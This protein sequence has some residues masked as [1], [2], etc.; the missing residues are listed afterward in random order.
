[1]GASTLLIDEDTCATNFMIRDSKMMQLVATDKEPITPFV[2]VVRSLYT[3]RQ[4]STVLVVGG[5]GDFF[6]VA[7]HVLLMDC[8][9]CQDAT[10]RAKEI[11]RKHP[12]TLPVAP[13]GRIQERFPITNTNNQW[14]PNGKVKCRSR[15]TIS[16]GD[17]ELNLGA[18]EQIVSIGQTHAI[19]GALQ[20]LASSTP[21]EDC[22]LLRLLQELDRSIE[23]GGLDDVLAPG[24]LHGDLV[25]PRLLE[26]SGAI[27]RLRRACVRQGR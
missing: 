20:K 13:F 6:N 14:S 17:T 16:Y 5:A 4:V 27:N 11:V 18:L 25:R 8:Y 19:A 9:K 1:M 23:Q 26:I 24:L 12:D 2:S 7:D 21:N 22:S 3:E 10:E 15:N